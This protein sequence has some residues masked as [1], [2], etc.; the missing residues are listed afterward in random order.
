MKEAL[1]GQG[2]QGAAMSPADL[3]RLLSEDTKTWSKV[4]RTAKIKVE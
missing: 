3:G 4:V 1:N 2:V